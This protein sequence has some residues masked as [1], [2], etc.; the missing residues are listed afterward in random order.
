[1][2]SE[3]GGAV[4][5]PVM[6]L[7]FDITPT[8]ARDFSLMIQACGMTCA[9]LAILYMRVQLEW[10]SLVFS[11]LGGVIGLIIGL[12][13]VDPYLTAPQKKMG[14]AS[15]FFSFAFALFL[16]NCY[17]KRRTFNRVQ[18]VTWWK[19]LILVFTGIMGGI[20]TSFAGNGLD[21][22]TFS[23]LTLFFR[24][25]EKVATPTSIILMS[26]HSLVAW[27]WRGCIMGDISQETYEFLYICAGVVVIGAPAGSV[28]GSH[29]HRL[30]LASLIYV[31]DTVALISAFV[32]VPQT[33]VLIGGSVGIIIG[34]FI[35]FFVVTQLGNKMLVCIERDEQA[36][37]TESDLEMDISETELLRGKIEMD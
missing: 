10:L 34:G 18:N 16:L 20:F 32:L 17:H 28:L 12:H 35:F 7:A 8:I 13:W 11:S 2:T 9:T 31:L 14:F 5:F 1:M 21:I 3:G 37:D 29:F 30:V 36:N 19:M 6:T 4:A 27:F 33:P 24:I 26:V 25:S 22:C 23:I 15:I